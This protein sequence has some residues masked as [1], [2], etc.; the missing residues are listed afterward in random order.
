M[1][2]LMCTDVKADALILKILWDNRNKCDVSIM[3]HF[4]LRFYLLGKDGK[5]DLEYTI[6]VTELMQ[7]SISDTRYTNLF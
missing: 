5:E 7:I 4:N 6:L 1:F 2:S 3:K